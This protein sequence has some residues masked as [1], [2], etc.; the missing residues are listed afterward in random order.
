MAIYLVRPSYLQFLKRIDGDAN[1]MNNKEKRPFILVNATIKKVET[2]VL[3]PLSKATE[4]RIK[5]QQLYKEH[6]SHLASMSTIIYEPN[7]R[8]ALSIA[9]HHWSIPYNERAVKKLNLDEMFEG[10]YKEQMSGILK[11]LRQDSSG[12]P[13][14]TVQQ[15][16]QN[17]QF[18]IGKIQE[19]KTDHV[20]ATSQIF[21][22][23]VKQNKHAQKY[24]VPDRENFN[25][26]NSSEWSDDQN[27][28]EESASSTQYSL[29]GMNKGLAKATPPLQHRKVEAGLSFARAVKGEKPLDSNKDNPP[30][31]PTMPYAAAAKKLPSHVSTAQPPGYVCE[32]AK[33][34]EPLSSHPNQSDTECANIIPVKSKRKPFGQMKLGNLTAV[35]SLTFAQAASLPKPTPSSSAAQPPLSF[36]QAASNNKP[37]H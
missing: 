5:K 8:E 35:P 28:D 29:D 25:P 19:F 13:S 22:D 36:A 18:T 21:P 4:K 32:Q 30:P 9:R 15:L 1:L 7:T 24:Q 6:Q 17:E 16:E 20:S 3:V 33:E 11:A 26:I 34:I 23:L 12:K 14:E 27:T 2:S 10:G 31:K 37:K